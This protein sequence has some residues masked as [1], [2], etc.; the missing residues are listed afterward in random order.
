MTNTTLCLRSLTAAALL[1][2]SI[3]MAGC[4]GPDTVRK[5]TTTEQTTTTTPAPAAASSSTTT[6]TIQ[7]TRP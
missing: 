3:L 2:G 4:S 5:T 6:T 7:Q 1:S